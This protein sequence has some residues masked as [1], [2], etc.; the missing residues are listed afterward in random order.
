MVVDEDIEELREVLKTVSEFINQLP[1]LLNK[2]FSA[3]YSPEIGEQMGKNIANYYKSLKESGLPEE[4]VLQL[5]EKYA[6]ETASN[7]SI[8]KELI[9]DFREK[10]DEHR[11][12]E[13]DI[14]DLKRKIE[15]EIR[16]KKRNK[17]EE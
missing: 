5:T 11:K 4:L 15:E 17:D 10:I 14:D 3:I 2:L 16:R 7:I 8:L 12:G 13:I 9:S 1:D 6:K